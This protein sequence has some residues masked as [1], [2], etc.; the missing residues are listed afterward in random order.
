MRTLTLHKTAETA[1][2][3]LTAFAILWKGGKALDATWLL[4]LF[5]AVLILMHRWRSRGAEAD[6]R[7]LPWLVWG[8]L[9][10]FVLLS[11]LSYETSVAKNYGLDE[12]LRDVSCVL[13]F[14]WVARMG[15]EKSEQFGRTLGRTVVWAAIAAALLGVA[16]YLFQPVNR[17]VGT[18]FDARFHT[19]FWPNAWAEFLLLAIP[20]AAWWALRSRRRAVTLL[21]F[22]LLGLLLGALF[23]SY[24]RG[25]VIAF[26]GEIALLVILFV[27][28][29]RTLPGL[30]RYVLGTVTAAFVG[31]LV[32]S[33]INAL[34]ARSYPVQSVGQKITFTADEGTSSFTERAQFWRQSLILSGERPLLGWGPYSFRFI[35]PRLQS[36]VLAT[37][38]HPHNFLLKLALERGWPAALLYTFFILV[39]LL[40]SAMRIVRRIRHAEPVGVEP[41]FLVAVAGVFAHNLIDYNLQ[42]VGIALPLWLGLGVLAA[43]L[44]RAGKVREKTAVRTAEVILASL[45]LIVTVH[46]G[47]YLALSSMGRHAHASGNSAEALSWYRRAEG[48]WFSRDLFLS[49]ADLLMQATA[50]V[51][52][53]RAVERSLSV[54][55][56]DARAWKLLGDISLRQF[57]TGNASK[58]FTQAYLLGRYNDIGI[59]RRLVESLLSTNP[60][61]LPDREKEFLSLARDFSGAI[62]HNTHFIAL[63]QNVEEFSAYLTALA[64]AYPKHSVM[65]NAMK[66]AAEKKAAEVRSEFSARKPG[67]LW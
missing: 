28:R 40:A 51:D 13:L 47:V 64:A 19:D 17:F 43:P 58:E 38:D 8:P 57:Q 49:Q 52:A 42:F 41:Y 11:I 48:E 32:F 5:S 10:G 12:L 29:R 46:E 61:S 21:R 15:P 44:V 33:S 6:E 20:L 53:R 36:D 50:Y 30:R 39:V 24:S 34:R 4:A 55:A 16:V 59:A 14:C 37:S 2:L 23:L 9:M 22:C 3:A 1:L 7:Q 27:V 67:T 54:N 56:E 45:L 62:A 18:F 25:G 31:L 35:Q 63:S 65:L 26:G 60:R 66:T